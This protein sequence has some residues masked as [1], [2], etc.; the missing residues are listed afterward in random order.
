MQSKSKI[1]NKNSRSN[2]FHRFKAQNRSKTKIYNNRNSNRSYQIQKTQIHNQNKGLRKRNLPEK[3]RFVRRVGEEEYERRKVIR[4]QRNFGQLLCVS[5]SISLSLSGNC[6]VRESK[7]KEISASLLLYYKQKLIIKQINK[8]NIGK[9]VK[10]RRGLQ[11]G[12]LRT[13]S[14]LMDSLLFFSFSSPFSYFQD[15]WSRKLHRFVNGLFYP[16]LHK[17]AKITF[18]NISLLA[19]QYFSELF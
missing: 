18:K 8:Q 19:W 17:Q 13:F 3:W 14:L 11:I 5:P 4:L 7:N 1:R 15:K 2:E 10:K 12:L 6:R 9:K 16:F